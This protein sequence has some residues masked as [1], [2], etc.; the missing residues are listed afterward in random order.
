VTP[1]PQYP[2]RITIGWI[3]VLVAVAA[4]AAATLIPGGGP[5]AEPL[6]ACVFCGERALADVLVNVILF[7]PLGVGLF[8][9]G[10]R[11]RSGLLAGALLSALVELTQLVIPGRDPSLGDIIANTGGTLAGMAFAW[12]V[13]ELARLDDR[14]S[15]RLSIAAACD[16]ALAVLVTGWLLQPSFPRTA[17]WGQWTPNL[18]NLEWYRGHVQSAR[19]DGV[20]VRSRRIEKSAWAREALRRGGPVEVDFVAGPPVSRLAPLF[21]VYDEHQREIFL[22]GPD[23]ED[24]VLRLRTRASGWRLHQPDLRAFG[25]WPALEP[26]VR[27]TVRAWS[28]SRGEWCLDG[29]AERHCGV[30]VTVG[31][32]WGILYHVERFPRWLRSLL[33]TGWCAVMLIPTGFLLRRRW[34]SVTAG[35][36]VILAF[37][38]LPGIVGLLPTRGL[39]WAG[40]AVGLAFG[41]VGGRVAR[42]NPALKRGLP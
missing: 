26:G 4:I 11:A 28:P 42:S 31:G 13:R 7:V 12:F 37:A 8:L 34:E 3:V 16:V 33:A 17:Y 27:D 30:G 24:L 1:A 25:A 22:V 32:G 19:I 15:A 41:L 2:S 35:A 23:R 36:I 39:E 18:G 20:E 40:A 38:G 29:P 9:L 6:S 5:R 14:A 10:R 21:S